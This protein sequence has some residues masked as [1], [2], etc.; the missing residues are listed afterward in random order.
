MNITLDIDGYLLSLN[1][2]EFLSCNTLAG[3]ACP[4]ISMRAEVEAMRQSLK[5]Q[6]AEA[7]IAYAYAVGEM[8]DKANEK[9]DSM[10]L[11]QKEATKTRLESRE[12]EAGESAKIGRR[13]SST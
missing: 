13:G 6:Y 12:D 10:L 2:S 1:T 8:R 9:L 7:E 3:G 5:D 4:N 11:G